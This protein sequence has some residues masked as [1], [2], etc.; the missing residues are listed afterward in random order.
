MFIKELHHPMRNKK[1]YNNI[2]TKQKNDNFKIF[3]KI[4]FFAL[5]GS[6]ICMQVYTLQNKHRSRNVCNTKLTY[7]G[8][9]TKR[10]STNVY[11]TNPLH[12]YH[13]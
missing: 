3:I 9:Y 4:H 13:Q 8:V 2:I 1:L 7:T 6:I 12:F 10:C 11:T 5:Y